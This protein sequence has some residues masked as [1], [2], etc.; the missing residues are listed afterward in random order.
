MFL[1]SRPARHTIGFLSALLFIF[2]S[3]TSA[4][5]KERQLKKFYSDIVVTPDGQVNVTE[6]ITF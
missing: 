3:L 2:C 1:P 5:Q 6:N 4:Q